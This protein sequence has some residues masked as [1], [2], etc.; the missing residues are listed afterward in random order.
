MLGQVSQ[1]GLTLYNFRLRS[2]GRDPDPALKW[3]ELSSPLR[4]IV[5]RVA[6]DCHRPTCTQKQ[7]TADNDWSAWPHWTFFKKHETE[8]TRSMAGGTLAGTSATESW[9][10]TVVRAEDHDRVLP[11]AAVGHGRRHIPSRRGR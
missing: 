2:P 1:I 9:P 10:R 4:E 7:Q 8:M 6:V 5:C 11:H 3:A